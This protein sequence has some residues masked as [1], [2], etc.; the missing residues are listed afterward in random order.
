MQKTNQ[1]LIKIL[2]L[3]FILPL[4]LLAEDETQIFTVGVTAPLTG[5]FASYGE[6]VKQGV[7]LARIELEQKNIKLNVK[8]EDACLPA[9]AVN[10][11]NKLIQIDKIQG[12]AANFCVIAMP[13]MSGA[14]QKNQIPSIHS[15]IASESILKLGNFIFTTDM[16]VRTE[17]KKLAEYA[18][19][20]LGAR[21]A[22]VLSIETDFGIDYRKFFSNRFE[23]LGG[24]VLYSQS[25]A[26]GVNDFK[27]EITILR[28][29]KPDVILAAHLGLTLGALLK[30]ARQLG[31][32]TP[33]LGTNEAEDPSVREVA[34]NAAEGLTFYVSQPENKTEKIKNFE[35][36]FFDKYNTKAGLAE[37]SYYDSTMLLAE[38][39]AFCK[40][41]AICT[42]D[43]IFKM[44]IY[45]GVSGRFSL[46]GTDES[47]RNF[48]LKQIKNG[49][50]EII[51]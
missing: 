21:T 45:D 29:K 8:Y 38:S 28:N 48:V 25:Q 43:Y 13:A 30:Q 31:I 26:I 46:I 1:T 22:G 12:L 18:Y 39:L 16:K 3:F 5:D 44:K 20:T 47:S 34:K 42:R 11:I 4:T 41:E 50:A 32:K 10:A 27:S 15:A 24:K 7:E 36:S 9:T 6:K 2:I 49:E 35:E 19:N 17:A 40:G 51:K 37:A 23:E 14:I 33:F